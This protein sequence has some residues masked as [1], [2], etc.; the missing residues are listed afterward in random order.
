MREG[1]LMLVCCSRSKGSCF[2]RLKVMEEMD[3]VE[4]ETPD[5]SGGTD[6]GGDF[7]VCGNTADVGRKGKELESSGKSRG[8]ME[9]VVL[10]VSHPQLVE[11]SKRV[12]A[13]GNLRGREELARG[14]VGLR[15]HRA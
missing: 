7:G 9:E 10:H 12:Q 8:S 6:G 5:P 11:G 1:Q 4:I 15:A 3:R 13:D 2:A 14:R